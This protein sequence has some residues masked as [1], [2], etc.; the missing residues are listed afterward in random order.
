MDG[1]HCG[2]AN[3][4]RTK[5][6]LGVSSGRSHK[7]SGKSGATEENVFCGICQFLLEEV[8]CRY[9]CVGE[10]IADRGEL[11]SNKAREFFAKHGVRLTLSMTYNPEANG[12]IE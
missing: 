2:H 7:P 10:V 8:F 5:K 6:V 1:Q 11:D 9:G 3:R 4:D 12:K